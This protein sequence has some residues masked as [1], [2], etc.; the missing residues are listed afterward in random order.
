MRKII[1]ILGLIAAIG[2]AVNILGLKNS[3]AEQTAAEQ[4]AGQWCETF[5]EERDYYSEVE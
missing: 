3:R 4:T 5:N 1:I 2:A